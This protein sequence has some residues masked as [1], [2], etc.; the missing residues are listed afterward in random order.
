[1]SAAAART[2]MCTYT[3]THI[4]PSPPRT[5]TPLL[6][7]ALTRAHRHPQ[8]HDK[9]RAG[10]HAQLA[11]HRDRASALEAVA[12]RRQLG[13]VHDRAGELAA[14]VFCCCLFVCLLCV[15]AV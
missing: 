4:H 2:H 11:A 13:G 10:G 12:R 5:Q 6:A 15:V 9:E 1:M 14:V 8:H 3:H 7:R